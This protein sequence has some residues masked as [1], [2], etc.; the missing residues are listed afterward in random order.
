MMNNTHLFFIPNEFKDKR[1]LV[2]GGTKGAGEA[3]VRR[4]GTAGA[5]CCYGRP[6][7]SAAGTKARALYAG[8]S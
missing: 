2:T 7:S 1:V 3:I 6:F 8:G 4:F 5:F